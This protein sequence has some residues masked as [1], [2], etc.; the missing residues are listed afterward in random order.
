MKKTTV[1][2]LVLLLSSFYLNAW[3]IDANNDK[4]T[5]E[6]SYFLIGDE[7]EPTESMKFPYQNVKSSLVFNCSSKNKEIGAYIYFSEAPNIPTTNISNGYQYYQNK[8][9]IVNGVD[10]VTL[11]QTWGSNFI[12]RLS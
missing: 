3:I 2:L 10:E 7:V 8:N 5:G 4:M 1:M 9:T 12:I 6:V 11:Y